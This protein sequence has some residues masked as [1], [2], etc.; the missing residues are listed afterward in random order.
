[1]TEP[2]RPRLPAATS[3][4]VSR[5]AGNDAER[6]VRIVI[7]DDSVVV[8]GL[9]SR[10]LGDDPGFE[11]AGTFRSG[12]DAVAGVVRS[13]PDVIILDIEMPDMDGVTAL[14]LLLKLSPGLTVIMASTLTERNADISLRCLSLGATDYIAKPS[15]LR[16]V[17]TSNEFRQ[18]LMEKV[19]SLSSQRR[20]RAQPPAGPK[21]LAGNVVE[22][23]PDRPPAEPI[24]T[25]ILQRCAPR[26]L[27]IGASTGGP[28][29]VLKLTEDLAPI[30]ERMPV[31]ITQHMPAMFTSMF[32][33]HLRK[34]SGLDAVEAIDQEPARPG[35]IYIAPGGRHMRVE[36]YGTVARIRLG[37]DP[38]VNFCR[39]SVD[40]LFD[41]AAA[42]YGKD[43]IAVVLTG[44]G[45]DGMRGASTLARL[46]GA[47][48]AQDE[49]SSVVWGMPGSVARA[50]ACNAI[51]PI[52][53]IG[54]A[55]RTLVAGGRL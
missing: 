37:D 41:S 26:A 39:P 3:G 46:G 50:G 27:L 36:P 11:V 21:P 55:L 7:V 10:W 23:R 6:P 25:R 1:M 43:S 8:R 48:I 35:R 20:K 53:K 5:S 18:E 29:A 22:L 28:Q 49:A 33:E 4:H 42:V 32:A 44:M 54:G 51:L 24:A 9:M 19:R 38:P 40:V 2:V 52:D 47:V 34:K 17:S 13:Q 15:S 30:V 45:S 31:L 16:E 12:V 14:P